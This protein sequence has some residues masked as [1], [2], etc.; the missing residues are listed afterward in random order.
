VDDDEMRRI[1]ATLPPTE[2]VQELVN[3][4]NDRGGLDN[5]SVHVVKIQAGES[6]LRR[7]FGR[8]KR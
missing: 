7:L 6:R 1:V 5:I 4:A 2:A 3:L 8:R